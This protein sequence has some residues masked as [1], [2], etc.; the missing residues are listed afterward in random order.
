MNS[1]EAEEK[2]IE[3][4]LVSDKLIFIIEEERNVLYSLTDIIPKDKEEDKKVY[5]VYEKGER[6]I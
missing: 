2:A 5:S 1:I 4:S 6:I 3:K